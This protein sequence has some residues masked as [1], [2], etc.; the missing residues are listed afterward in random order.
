[1]PKIGVR[2]KRLRQRRRL[3]IRLLGAR[4]G[5]SGST[6]SLIENDRVSP[7]IDTLGAI[8]EALGST[9]SGF[10]ASDERVDRFP[11]YHAADLPEIGSETSIS[12]KL[13][14]LNYPDRHMQ[15]LKET[16]SPG[17]D[18]GGTLSHAAEEGGVVI[19]GR[20]EVTVGERVAVLGPGDGYYF[21]S[22]V[23]HRFRNVGDGLAEIVSAITPPSY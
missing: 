16:Y 19:S 6:I 18:T 1:M 13:I 23:Q 20:V 3:S 7:S 15:I 9:L 5:V 10:L 8:L 12:Y 21:D 4:S 17:A 11:F 22:H 14:G 2:L